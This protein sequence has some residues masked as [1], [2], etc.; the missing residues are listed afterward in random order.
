MGGYGI[1][2]CCRETKG[3]SIIKRFFACAPSVLDYWWRRAVFA[4]NRSYDGLTLKLLRLDGHPPIAF[5]LPLILLLFLILG[6]TLGWR[7]PMALAALL[8]SWACLYISARLAAGRF[9]LGFQIAI[10]STA[11]AAVWFLAD[12]KAVETG[13]GPS[14]AAI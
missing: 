2:A 1:K 10:I 3:N 9:F 11:A 14:I 6:P 7:G 8:A 5:L 13:G 4:F 12:P